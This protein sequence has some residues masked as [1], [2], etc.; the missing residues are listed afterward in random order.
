MIAVLIVI[1]LYIAFSN[2]S[3]NLHF[4]TQFIIDTIGGALIIFI[5]CLVTMKNLQLAILLFFLVLMV[6]FIL[7][8]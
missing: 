2:H 8:I 1:G 7:G 5:I 4:A 6:L 3:L